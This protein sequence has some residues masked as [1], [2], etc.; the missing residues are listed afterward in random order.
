MVI[1]FPLRLYQAMMKKTTLQKQIV[2]SHKN[3]L[4]MPRAKS[5]PGIRNCSFFCLTE[6]QC[7]WLCRNLFSFSESELRDV[8]L[9]TIGNS[10]SH[11]QYITQLHMSLGL[12][13]YQGPWFSKKVAKCSYLSIKISI[14]GFS[15]NCPYINTGSHLFK[16]DSS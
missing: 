14:S 1:F 3:A 13:L 7:H 2:L 11:L 16:I 10:F 4:I 15:L 5:A 6:C 12:F 8:S 9:G